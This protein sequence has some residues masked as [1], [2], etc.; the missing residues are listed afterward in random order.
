MSCLNNFMTNN[1]KK[2]ITHNGSFHSDDIF[3]A[4]ALSLML[5]K[6]GEGFE[7]IRTRDPEAIKTGDFVFDVGGIYDAV[8][9]RFDHHQVGGAGKGAEDIEY[10][11]FGLVWK[12][13]GEMLAGGKKAAEIINKRLCAPVDAWDNGID[14]VENKYEIRP[15][16]IQNI[17]FAMHPT[18]K[19]ENLNI[20]DVFLKCVEVAKNVLTREIIQARDMLEAEAAVI[21]AY[22]NSTDKRIIILDKN[23]PFEY[24][25]TAFPEPL[26][27][28]YPRRTEGN[29]G[30]KAIRKNLGTF[31]NRKNLPS[32]WGGV[33]EDELQKITAVNDA[34]FCHHSLFVAAAK[35]KEG[36]IKLA[37]I[38]VES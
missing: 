30:V 23:Y 6:G 25:L 38:A 9:N 13:F 24:T 26:F 3:A 19:E 22:N 29:W 20:D 2:L 12:K 10:A 15:Y 34:V 8:K 35:S 7:I 27:A 4:A 36:A 33:R 28:V 16:Y 5:E 14:L 21:Y 17:F 18:W 11:S 1:I 32:S 31:E 37:Q